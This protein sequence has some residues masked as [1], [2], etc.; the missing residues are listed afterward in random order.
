MSHPA[1]EPDEVGQVRTNGATVHVGVCRV[2]FE[3][4]EYVVYG[5]NDHRIGAVGAI[6]NS[7]QHISREL[8]SFIQMEHD[9]L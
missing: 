7:N 3:D 6:E 5:E 9:E 8:N 4:D 2:T 1:I